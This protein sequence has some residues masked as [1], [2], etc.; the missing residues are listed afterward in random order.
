MKSIGG[1]L[2]GA[3][4]LLLLAA[5]GGVVFPGEVPSWTIMLGLAAVC[6]VLSV[7]A[8]RQSKKPTG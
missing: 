6:A 7:I 8:F 3:S 5:V 2:G 1:I 4:L